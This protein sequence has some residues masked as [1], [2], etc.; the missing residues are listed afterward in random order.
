M[1]STGGDLEP[2]PLLADLELDQR[3]DGDLRHPQPQAVLGLVV[4]DVPVSLGAAM[5]ARMPGIAEWVV[6]T[7]DRAGGVR[8]DRRHLGRRSR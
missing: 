2:E 4:L 3:I 1:V 6:G 7:A 8:P 5:H